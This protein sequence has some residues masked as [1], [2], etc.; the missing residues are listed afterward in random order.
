MNLSQATASN[1]PALIWSTVQG[2]DGAGLTFAVRERCRHL[3]VICLPGN[4]DERPK[5]RAGIHVW[6]NS[7]L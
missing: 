7:P 5:Q 4:D 1:V 3:S 6:E 2:T